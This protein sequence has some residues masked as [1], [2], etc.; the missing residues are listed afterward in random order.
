MAQFPNI[1][2]RRFTAALF[3]LNANNFS[4]FIILKKKENKTPQLHVSLED[5][6]YLDFLLRILT[7]SESRRCITILKKILHLIF[8]QE[9]KYLFLFVITG[10]YVYGREGKLSTCPT[11]ERGGNHPLG[12][13]LFWPCKAGGYGVEI[14]LGINV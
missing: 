13:E 1:T 12:S 4:L 7:P 3:L 10:A 2:E 14:K 8:L 9:R 11:W 5:L 6:E